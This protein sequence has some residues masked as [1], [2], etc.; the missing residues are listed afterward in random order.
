MQ[1]ASGGRTVV[2]AV[3]AGLGAAV[4]LALRFL[5]PTQLDAFGQHGAQA[6]FIV[7]TVVVALAYGAVCGLIAA[8]VPRRLFAILI[9]TLVVAPALWLVIAAAAVK[10]TTESMKSGDALFATILMSPVYVVVASFS[11]VGLLVF[12]VIFSLVLHVFAQRAA[13]FAPNLRVGLLGVWALDAVLIS[14]PLRSLPE[15]PPAIVAPTP[16]PEPALL[17]CDTTPFS[18][19][20]E[21]Q[22][23]RGPARNLE[24]EHVVEYTVIGPSSWSADDLARTVSGLNV[25]IRP[26]LIAGQPWKVRYVAATDLP[27]TIR[28]K[29]KPPKGQDPVMFEAMLQSQLGSAFSS[30]LHVTPEGFFATSVSDGLAML[31][32]AVPKNFTCEPADADVTCTAEKIEVRRAGFVPRLVAVK[33]EAPKR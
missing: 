33:A 12:T 17:N 23:L 4:A 3:S 14:V 32:P 25:G 1:N 8:L 22:N 19:L 15:P 30:G 16:T 31:P 7:Q 6:D 21:S 18:A 5:F 13:A 9:N 24:A 20:T 2:A 10:Q 26:C 27:L 11:V 29:A 28:F